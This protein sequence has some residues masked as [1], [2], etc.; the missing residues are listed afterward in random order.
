MDSTVLL[1]IQLKSVIKCNTP[2]NRQPFASAPESER[3]WRH[4][5]EHI[6]GVVA[7]TA[8]SNPAAPGLSSAWAAR[9]A[10]RRGFAA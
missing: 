5:R 2:K 9:V 3:R 4:A 6:M 8:L 1:R 10:E 7:D